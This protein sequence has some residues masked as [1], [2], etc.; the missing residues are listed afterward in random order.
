[1]TPEITREEVAEILSYC[2]ETGVFT[3]KVDRRGTAKAGG[4]A[5][6]RDSTGYMRV[7]VKGCRYLAH[8]LAFL[9]MTG[10]WPEQHVDH[11]DG[12]RQNNRWGNLRDVPPMLNV[13]NQREAQKHNQ[14]GLLGVTPY[15][16]RFMAKIRVN[17]KTRYLGLFDSPEV[18]HKVYLAHKRILHPGNTL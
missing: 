18:A 5:G 17:G 11:R 13:Q 10:A 9:L 7:S 12:D 4:I 2:P 14:T 8:R 1:M 3:W 16:G 15:R 6:C